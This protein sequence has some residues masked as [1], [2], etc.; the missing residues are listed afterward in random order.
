[1]RGFVP[2]RQSW[3]VPRGALRLLDCTRSDSEPISS[4]VAAMSRKR[5]FSRRLVPTAVLVRWHK[6][7]TSA[8]SRAVEL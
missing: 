1:M 7:A 6:S 5:G 3:A 2:S 4:P 8:A